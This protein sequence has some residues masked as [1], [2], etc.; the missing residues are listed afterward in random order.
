MPFCIKAQRNACICVVFA[1]SADLAPICLTFFELLTSMSA[2]ESIIAHFLIEV[3]DIRCH[4][5]RQSVKMHKHIVFT[6]LFDSLAF[7]NEQ[8]VVSRRMEK[9]LNREYISFQYDIRCH[10]ISRIFSFRHYVQRFFC[11][12]TGRCSWE[13]R[14]HPHGAS[15]LLD[16]YRSSERKR[17]RFIIEF[18][19]LSFIYVGHTSRS[20]GYELRISPSAFLIARK[21]VTDCHPYYI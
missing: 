20:D 15:L 13:K 8:R 7:Q 17:T 10:K 19:R 4:K 18:A 12:C 14:P 9:P 3:Y 5:L 1:A 11:I 16:V 21:R 2:C 6:L